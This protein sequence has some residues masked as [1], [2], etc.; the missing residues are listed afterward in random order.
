MLLLTYIVTA[1]DKRFTVFA[2]TD[3]NAT[4]KDGFNIGAGID[5]QMTIVYFKAQAFV[6]PDLRGKKYLEF[7]GTPIGFNQHLFNDSFRVY[8]GFKLGLIKRDYTHPMI[9]FE[10]GIEYYFNSYNDGL[11]IG[12][13]GSYDYRIDGKEEEIDIKPYWRLSGLFKIGFTI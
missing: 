2:Y 1:Q 3:P 5:Y 8:E 12:F 7:T 13:G 4:L 10:S 9:G 11:F 6:F